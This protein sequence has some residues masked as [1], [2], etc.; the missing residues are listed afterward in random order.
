[1]QAVV[2]HRYGSPDVLELQ[3]IPKPTPAEDQ[4]LIRVHAASVNPYDWHFLRGA[5]SFIRL[6]VGMRRPKFPRLGADVAGIVEAVGAKVAQFKPGDVVFGTAKGSFAEYACAVASQLAV[7]PQGISFVQAACLPIAGTTALQGLRDKG[8]VQ[9][10]QTVLIN[11]AAGGVGI[12][13]VQIAKSLGARVTGVCST[14]NVEFLRSIGANEVIDYTH[15]DFARSAQPYDLLF[16]LVGNRSLADY[17]RAL[18]PRGTYISC[19][20][21]GPDQ[22]TW[23]LL[24][25]VLQNAVRSRFV[26][27]KMPSLLA[28]INRE[29][30]AILADLVQGGKVLPIVDCTY[31]LREIAEAIRHVESGHVRGKVVVAIA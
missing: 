12:F 14:R 6:F 1:M 21:G 18:Q 10:G 5:P 13:A 25:G 17:L 28:K 23:N 29:D 24:A 8:K 4:V 2:Y 27:Q 11:G 15:E 22:S 19:G 30:L 3:E 16:D 31:S 9:T 26:S 20:G 7:K